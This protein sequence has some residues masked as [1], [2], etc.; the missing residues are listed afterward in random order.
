MVHTHTTVESREFLRSKGTIR[1]LVDIVDKSW[2]FGET[3]R[4]YELSVKKN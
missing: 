4:F 1:D 2:M 3:D